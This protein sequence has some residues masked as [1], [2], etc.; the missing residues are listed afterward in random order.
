[1][2][3]EAPQSPAQFRCFGRAV[4][5]GSD[6]RVVGAVTRFATADSGGGGFGLEQLKGDG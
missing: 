2:S 5:C 1:M 4:V 3:R 6:S